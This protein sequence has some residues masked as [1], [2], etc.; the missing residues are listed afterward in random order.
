MSVRFRPTSF[1]DGAH[2]PPQPNGH[3]IP[4]IDPASE[5]IVGELREADADEVAAAVAAARRAFDAGPWPRMSADQR[6]AILYRVR[7]LILAHADELTA[8]EV[9]NTGL[10]IASVGWQVSRAA[11]NFEMFADV[12]SLLSGQ[13]YTQDPR[14]LTYVTRE[15]KGVAALIAPW[16]APLALASM[17]IAT[18]IAFG[19]SCVLK[20]SE[21]T[22]HS[23]LRLVE[24]IDEAGMPRGVVNLVNGRGEV[25]GAALV[26]HPGI[27]MVGF[28]G[29]SETGRSIMATAGRNLKPCILELGGKSASIVTNS[30]DLNQAIDG[31]LLGIFSNNGQQC[32]AGSRILVQRKI[33]DAYLDAFV[34]RSRAIRIGAP[35]D[36]AT[37]LG[38]LA[39]R[40]HMEKV[41]SYVDVAQAEGGLLLA[42]GRRPDGFDTGYYIEPTVVLA[43]SN[44]ARICQEEIFGPF[45]SVILFDEPEEAVAIA[46]ASDFGLV[47]YLWSR[48]LSET[49]KISRDIRAGTIWVNTPMM[50][51]LRAP[52]G[53][54]KQSGI[55]RD[56][57]T[58]SADFFTEFKTTS[59]PY[60]PIAMNR[61]GLG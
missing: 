47:G 30:A 22:P 1:I 14:Y 43:R 17:R 29:G 8:L 25:T 28:T 27:D 4:V 41:L 40:R 36:R 24:L 44:E 18:C 55:G 58:S 26:S 15:P 31:T 50:R 13:T 54:Y 56:G 6:K 53:G 32:L 9:M 52:F 11:A 37:E 51:E 35:L 3:D 16:N 12:A 46:N 39:F 59:I 7:D 42:G 57:M 34:R 48:D 19:N 5:R 2:V 10:P 23:I 38:P 21:Y 60:D 61:I 49:M 45:A 20:P 33:A